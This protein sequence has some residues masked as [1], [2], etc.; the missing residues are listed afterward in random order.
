MFNK[1]AASTKEIGYWAEAAEEIT[2]FLQESERF[3]VKV[4]IG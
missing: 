1:R 4:R 2:S 3:P